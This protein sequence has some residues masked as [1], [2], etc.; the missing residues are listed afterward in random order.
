MC[1]R[2]VL[3]SNRKTSRV[4]YPTR[5]GVRL[6]LF[7]CV[8]CG[9]RGGRPRRPRRPQ[10]VSERLSRPL[11]YLWVWVGKCSQALECVCVFLCV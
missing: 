2:G 4:Y 11:L 1:L 3:N 6:R 10:R 5:R 7:V 8:V 9:H